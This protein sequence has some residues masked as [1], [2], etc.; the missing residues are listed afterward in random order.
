MDHIIRTIHKYN[1][2]FRIIKQA[3]KKLL[4]PPLFFFS[5]SIVCLFLL[6]TFPYR[7]LLDSIPPFVIY[8]KKTLFFNILFQISLHKFIQIS[9]HYSINISEPQNQFYGLLLKYKDKKHKN[10]SGFRQAI[11]FC[12]P[13]KS[14]IFS[15][16]SF[17]FKSNNL[18]FNICIAVSLFIV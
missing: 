10:E 12:T 13:F 5:F 16:F 4:N 1:Q 7:S 2:Y 14:S 3:D 8:I 9:V 17:S 11:S 18:D 6:P 15:L